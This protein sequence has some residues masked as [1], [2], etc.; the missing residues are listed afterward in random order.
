MKYYEIDEADEYAFEIQRAKSLG[1]MARE[2][3]GKIF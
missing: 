3:K 1:L 2:K